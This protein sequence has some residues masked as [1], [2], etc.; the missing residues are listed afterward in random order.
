MHKLR[1]CIVKK[2]SLNSK[3]CHCTINES[4]KFKAEIIFDLVFQLFFFL[5]N[6]AMSSYRLIQDFSLYENRRR[7]FVNPLFFDHFTVNKFQD[8]I[9]VNLSCSAPILIHDLILKMSRLSS[10]NNQRSS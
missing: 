9:S 4:S 3:F 6:F 8:V 7:R 1:I 5:G 2:H 10:S